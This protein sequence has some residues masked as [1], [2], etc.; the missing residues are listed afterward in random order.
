MSSCSCIFN[1][2]LGHAQGSC[3]KFDCCEILK[4]LKAK[5]IYSWH[6]II[7]TNFCWCISDNKVCL[8]LN[9]EKLGPLCS[10]L[11]HPVFLTTAFQ[12]SPSLAKSKQKR[13]K[14]CKSRTQHSEVHPEVHCSLSQ[15]RWDPC[16]F[17]V[18]EK[19]KINYFLRWHL[20]NLLQT[21]KLLLQ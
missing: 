7:G 15:Q 14:K 20:I 2:S 16:I 3:P 12:P 10:S 6:H 1:H 11:A 9:T 5:Y 21:P 18:L 8:E 4:P 17:I 19:N 13:N